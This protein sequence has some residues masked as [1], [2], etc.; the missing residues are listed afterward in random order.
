MRVMRSFDMSRVCSAALLSN[1]PCPLPCP[2]LRVSPRSTP[3]CFFLRAFPLIV[4]GVSVELCLC[5]KGFD[6]RARACYRRD[7]DGHE[8]TRRDR[9]RCAISSGLL[10]R[11]RRLQHDE[12]A[13]QEIASRTRHLAT[14]PAAAAIRLPSSSSLYDAFHFECY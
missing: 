13:C 2:M 8:R 9:A 11:Q 3:L 12:R 6:A 4:R 14:P 5:V 10:T 7:S 1:P